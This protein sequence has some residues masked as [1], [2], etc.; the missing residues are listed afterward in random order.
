MIRTY[1]VA[2]L[3]AAASAHASAAQSGPSISRDSAASRLAGT[4]DGRFESD[5]GPAGTI[6]LVLAHDPSWRMSLEMSHGDKAIHSRASDVKVTG[7]SVSWSQD[8]EGTTCVASAT[9]SGDTMT[10]EGSCA[11]HGTF[12]M[13]LKKK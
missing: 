10:G 2:L 11:Q 9:V 8:I 3:L 6:Q 1:A 13:E 4:W 7:T 12:K 5:H